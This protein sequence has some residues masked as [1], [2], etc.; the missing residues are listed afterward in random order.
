MTS[1]EKDI[2]YKS[3]TQR[4]FSLG[5][6]KFITDENSPINFGLIMEKLM[7]SKRALYLTLKDLETDRLI[8]Q[9]KVGRKSIIEITDEGRNALL[10]LNLHEDEQKELVYQSVIESTVSQLENEGIISKEWSSEER[11]AFIKKISDSII[12]KMS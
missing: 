12:S 10:N 7:I 11:S 1:S 3:L 9:T 8:T 2:Q 4:E 5:I 6:L